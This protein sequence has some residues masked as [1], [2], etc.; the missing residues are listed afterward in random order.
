MGFYLRFLIFFEGF[1]FDIGPR[2]RLYELQDIKYA[3]ILIRVSQQALLSSFRRVLIEDFQIFLDDLNE[4]VDLIGYY[5]LISP[6]H[7]FV[8]CIDNQDEV[9]RVVLVDD[10]V[11]GLRGETIFLVGKQN[12]Q[13]L[14]VIRICVA[15]WLLVL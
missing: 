11:I 2:S 3:P 13:I 14:L 7:Q 9:L 4:I 6:G 8:L 15:P 10:I 12:E 5:F 1:P